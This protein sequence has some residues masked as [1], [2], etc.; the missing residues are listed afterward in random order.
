MMVTRRLAQGMIFLFCLVI[1][2][3][4]ANIWGKIILERGKSQF[5]GSEL[6]GSL[7]CSKDRKK[8]ARLPGGIRCG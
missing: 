6:E 2:L 8:P 4:N 5:K 7:L 1:F 3:K